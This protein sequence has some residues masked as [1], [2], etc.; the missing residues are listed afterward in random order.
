MIGDSVGDLIAAKAAGIKSIAVLTGV[1]SRTDLEPYADFILSDIS[2][3][4]P[5]LYKEG[6]IL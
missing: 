2:S 1:A 6:Q 4:V 3:L 5:W